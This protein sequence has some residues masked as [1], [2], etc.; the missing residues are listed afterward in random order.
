MGW[1]GAVWSAM[2]TWRTGGIGLT[3]A[4]RLVTGDLPGPGHPGLGALLDAARAPAS[5]EELAGERAA[6]AGFVAAYRGGVVRTSVPRGRRRVRASLSRGVAV[7]VAAGVVVLAAGGTALAAE[8]GNL[9]A[10]VQQR[11][12]GMFSSLGVP[13]P[14]TGVRSTGAGPAGVAGSA[15]PSTSGTTGAGGTILGPSDPATVALCRAWDAERKDPHGKAMAAQ[16][17]RA[18][19]AA[20]G[21]QS[22][23]PA[24]CAGLLT[25]PPTQ[26]PPAGAATT[27]PA[28]PRGAA[29]HPDGG[30]GNG[31]GGGHPPGS[32]TSHPTPGPHR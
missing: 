25:P 31:N 29:S 2:R 1:W 20:A 16:T 6:V 21:G 19:S 8:T 9:P 5:G 4:D 32:N 15:R 11:A 26:N 28:P 17:R 12:H 24:F 23:V 22:R 18:L 10:G 27:H 30:S 14:G 7:K 13:A 3:E